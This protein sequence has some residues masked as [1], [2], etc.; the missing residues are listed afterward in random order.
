MKIQVKPRIFVREPY[1]S[2]LTD[3]QW[4][5]IKHLIPR[6]KSTKK[7]GGRPELYPRREIVNAILYVLSSGCRW[8]DLPHDLPGKSISWKRFDEWSKKGVWKK[9]NSFLVIKDRQ[10]V[11][12]KIRQQQQSLT[13]KVL[14]VLVS[15]GKSAMTQVRKSKAGKDI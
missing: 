3:K 4:E 1:E 7:W 13:R 8:V 5:T 9:L 6:I 11:K 14:K 2:D 10:S 15:Q 12:K